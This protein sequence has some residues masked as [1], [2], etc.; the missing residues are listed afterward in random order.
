VPRPRRWPG[1][2]GPYGRGFGAWVIR[3]NNSGSTFGMFDVDDK[4]QITQPLSQF[5]AAQLLNLEWVK[6]G[7]E[8]HEVYPP[9][10]DIRDSAGHTLV[11]SYAVK[12]PDGKWALLIINKDQE[13]AHKVAVSFHNAESRRDASFS[14]AVEMVTFGSA[15]YR[16]DPLKKH[17]DSQG[18]AK[19][20]VTIDGTSKTVELPAAS[21]VVLRGKLGGEST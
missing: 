14:G 10:S 20:S 9:E 4:H 21:V 6:P 2:P 19:R 12:R 8:R 16:W 17:A 15:Q 11:T 13:N 5:Y 7:G 3:R 18:P 1:P